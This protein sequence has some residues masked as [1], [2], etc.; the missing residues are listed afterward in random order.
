MHQTYWHQPAPSMTPPPPYTKPFLSD[1]ILRRHTPNTRTRG[2]TTIPTRYSVH[3]G[4][5][6]HYQLPTWRDNPLASYTP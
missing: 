3:A 4:S 2:H 5:N 1:S 6:A